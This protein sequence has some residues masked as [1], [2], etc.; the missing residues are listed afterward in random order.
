MNDT[1]GPA[2]SAWRK[3]SYSNGGGGCIEVDDAHPGHV[4]DSKDPAGPVLKF[5]PT[6][7]TAFVTA[8]VAGEFG[9][10]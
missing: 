10:S 6:A 2:G 7:W 1:L 8:T 9:T 4:R 5:A 3:S